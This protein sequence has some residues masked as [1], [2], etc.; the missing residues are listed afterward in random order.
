[1]RARHWF[2]RGRL[3][4]AALVLG[5]TSLIVAAGT[6]ARAR[7]YGE[8]ARLHAFDQQV[9]AARK[10]FQEHDMTAFFRTMERAPRP[11][12]AAYRD[13]YWNDLR[14]KARR[15]R[16]AWVCTLPRSH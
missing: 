15:L 7:W 10:S 2:M 12:W 16:P 1:D 8:T 6:L 11:P 13:P 5:A 3:R 4:A 14:E 9:Q